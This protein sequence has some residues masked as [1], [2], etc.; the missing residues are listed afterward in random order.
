M[1]LLLL[2][3]GTIGLC[4]REVNKEGSSWANVPVVMLIAI[5]LGSALSW[6]G[7]SIQ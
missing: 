7:C 5:L 1:I 6:I 2:T 4:I 3:T